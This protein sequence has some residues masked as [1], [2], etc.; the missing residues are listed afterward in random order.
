VALS[1]E[2]PCADDADALWALLEQALPGQN[3]DGDSARCV[4]E[5]RTGPASL[6]QTAWEAA[7]AHRTRVSG[8]AVHFPGAGRLTGDVTVDD[9]LRWTAIDEVRVL[10]HGQASREAVVVTRDFVRPRWS[11]GLLVLDV[12][13]A[14]GGTLVPFEVPNPTPCCAGLL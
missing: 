8:R 2:V 6:R 1:F 14:A 12:Q 10:A 3:W 13:P 11:T 9:I 5:R 4:G 7:E